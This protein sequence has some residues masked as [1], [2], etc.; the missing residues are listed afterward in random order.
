[1]R[2]I[3]LQRRHRLGVRD[4][5]IAGC[6]NPDFDSRIGF[7]IGMGSQSRVAFL[8]DIKR[9]KWCGARSTPIRRGTKI[10]VGGKISMEPD[11]VGVG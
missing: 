10:P 1:M 4:S 6:L 5:H 11:T 7:V 2:M 9:P 3:S 8:L